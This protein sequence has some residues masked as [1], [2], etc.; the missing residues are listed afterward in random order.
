MLFPEVVLQAD[1]ALA[2]EA[3]GLTAAGWFF[4][5]LAWTTIVSMAVFCYRKVLS[6]AE[7]R[8][9]ASD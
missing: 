4:V 7:E 9:R 3:Q 2:K 6:K 8:S 5:A 1:Q